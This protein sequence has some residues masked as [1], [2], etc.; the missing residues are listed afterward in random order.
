MI[1]RNLSLLQSEKSA[2][3]TNHILKYLS[4]HIVI[5]FFTLFVYQTAFALN[6]SSSISFL[7]RGLLEKEKSGKVVQYDDY[8]SISEKYLSQGKLDSSLLYDDSA[9]IALKKDNDT[10]IITYLE[11]NRGKI[12]LNMGNFDKA[13]ECFYKVLANAEKEKDTV[14]MIRVFIN[15]GTAYKRLERYDEALENY[16]K[17]YK[18]SKASN[19]LEGIAYSYSIGLIYRKKGDNSTALQYYYS[20]LSACKELNMVNDII[21]IYNNISNIYML[22]H[23]YDEAAKILRKNI[24][25]SD[26]LG[27]KRQIGIAYANLGKT[28]ELA[29]QHDSALYYLEKALTIFSTNKYYNLESISLKM[30][31]NVYTKMNN[32]EK[33]FIT[34]NKHI[35]LS[36]SLSNEKSRKQIAELKVKYETEKKEKENNILFNKVET[37]KHKSK[38]LIIVSVVLF[39]LGI[40]SLILFYFIRKHAITD[41]KLAESEAA[42]LEIELESKKKDLALS[43]LMMS[44]NL[45]FSNKLIDEL[46]NLSGYVTEEGYTAFSRVIKQLKSQGNDAAWSEF[47][48]RFLNIH[49]DFYSRLLEEFPNLTHNEL[50]ICAFLR[51]GM[52]TKDICSI[53]FQNI[54]AVETTRFRLRKKINLS[55]GDNLSTFLQAY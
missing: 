27:Y 15:I 55:T 7:K 10:L 45:E 8:L 17:S 38:Y 42:N 37:E 29:K 49:T 18:L 6:D 1:F 24:L 34:F 53:T 21:N 11:M 5:F 50:K 3:L 44:K 26:S 48:T 47:E 30:L 51:L 28:K 12:Y 23:R 25:L 39:L 35:R 54:R 19:N 13:L 52:N 9:H 2:K 41:K 32:Y 20:A 33:A 4:I 43:A 14:N 16:I 46:E 22:E 31:S 36:D 40:L